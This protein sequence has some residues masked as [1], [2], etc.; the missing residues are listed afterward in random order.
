[1]PQ[2]LKSR[3]QPPGLLILPTRTECRSKLLPEG[4]C[5]GWAEQVEI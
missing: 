5:S 4:R 3:F 2:E 1:M